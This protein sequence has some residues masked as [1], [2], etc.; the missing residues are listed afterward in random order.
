MRLIRELSLLLNLI[1]GL[2]ILT[3]AV[4]KGVASIAPGLGSAV[5]FVGRTFFANSEVPLP[6]RTALPM[7]ALGI[8]LF[9]LSDGKRKRE[10]AD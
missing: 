6:V 10:A 4:Y 1:A 5:E 9:F 2:I 8:V 7:L 3:W